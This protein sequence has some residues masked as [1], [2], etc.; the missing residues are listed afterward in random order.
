MA[1]SSGVTGRPPAGFSL[2]EMKAIAAEAG[3][4]P[5]LVERAAHLIPLDS[6]VSLLERVLGG[7]V[8]Y[9]LDAY[10]TANLT[11][12]RTAHL[13]SAVRASAEQQGEGQADSSGMSWHSVGEGSQILVTA[14]AE[15]EGTRV[16]VVAD[17]RGAFAI[18]GTFTLLGALAVAI[19]VV[20]A[21]E[22]GALQSAAVGLS[23]IAG[24]IAGTLVLGRAVWASTARRIRAKVDGLMDMVGR[25]L[26]ESASEAASPDSG[27]KTPPP[28]L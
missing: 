15:G 11:D 14:H 13:L 8:K 24:G 6:R 23:L 25:S 9:R 20:A 16:R 5:I 28:R 3:L 4:D 26:G 27:L 2:G 12:H 7:P 17:R 18:T 1:R 10:F 19:A 21:G 22:I